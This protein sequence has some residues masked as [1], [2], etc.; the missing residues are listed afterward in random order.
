MGTIELNFV[1]PPQLWAR[2]L[3]K[4][5]SERLI[6]ALKLIN[7]TPELRA[8]CEHNVACG[9]KTVGFYKAFDKKAAGKRES[10]RAAL[11]RAC[12]K[13]AKQ[14]RQASDILDN[15]FNGAIVTE[16]GQ[17]VATAR[18]FANFKEA[19]GSIDVSKG[20]PLKKCS[21]TSAV[22]LAW[23]LLMKFGRQRAGLTQN[24]LWHRLAETLY[25]N[26][27]SFDYLR[28]EHKR[29]KNSDPDRLGFLADL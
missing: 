5:Q 17:A 26:D 14:L 2:P 21:K 4:R 28:Y 22:R 25:G 11:K 1:P 9:L 29:L 8:R 12:L 20:A 6:E 24:G 10:A 16:I 19:I 23:W 27:V 18:R 7:P 13:D 15:N 3:S